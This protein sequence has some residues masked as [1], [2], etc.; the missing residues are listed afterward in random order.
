MLRSSSCDYS[1]AYIFD[2]ETITVALATAA[3]P[4]NANK[5]V[6]FKNCAPF[7]NCIS[8]INNT[9]VDNAHDL[10]VVMSKK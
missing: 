1:D 3:A 9:Q 4:N 10:D 7:T 8:R 2:E 6:I 5:K